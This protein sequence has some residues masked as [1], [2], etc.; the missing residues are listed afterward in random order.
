MDRHHY[1]TFTIFGN[2]TAPLHLD[3][4]RGFGKAMHDE[5]S[6]LAPI[7]QCCII[8]SSTLSQLL[9]FHNGPHHLSKLMKKS[10][11]ADPLNPVLLE[12]HMVAIDRRLAIVLHTVRECLRNHP[13]EDVIIYDTY[14][15][16]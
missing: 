2:D 11:S 4:G 13:I 14:L 7:Y 12:T 16:E 15:Y 5:L 8:R 3:H 10:L 6:I 1:E 9:K